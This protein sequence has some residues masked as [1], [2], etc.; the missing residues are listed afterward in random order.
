VVS[1]DAWRKQRAVVEAAAV[2]TPEQWRAM[3][4]ELHLMGCNGWRD[5]AEGVADALAAMEE[6]R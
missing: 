6:G 2:L 5:V 3:A 1:G 4:N